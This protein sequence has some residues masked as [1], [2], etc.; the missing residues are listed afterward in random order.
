MFKVSDYIV[1]GNAGV[2]RVEAIGPMDFGQANSKDYYTLCP[3]YQRGSQVFTPVDNDKVIMRPVMSDDE[4][5]E[6]I[7]SIADIDTL[8]IEDEKKREDTYKEAIRTCE[9]R[10][11][12]SVIKTLHDR[13]EKRIHQ[14]K[15]A[16]SSDEKYMH[17][18]KENLHGELAFALQIPKDKVEEFILSRISSHRKLE[19]G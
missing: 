10:E 17:I 1:Y 5:R 18:A 4:A 8:V 7:D 12:V 11:W 14:G 3:V 13:T 9:P 19:I 2:C 6:L 16:T 15:K